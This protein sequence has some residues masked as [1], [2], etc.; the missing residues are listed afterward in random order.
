MSHRIAL[1]GALAADL[2]FPSYPFSACG[3]DREKEN[4]QRRGLAT[5]IELNSSVHV[6][7]QMVKENVTTH[8]TP[9][10]QPLQPH[11]NHAQKM[12]D[13]DE[14]SELHYEWS[15]SVQ[16]LNPMSNF[17]TLMRTQNRKQGPQ[18]NKKL[19]AM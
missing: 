10:W 19:R 2:L 5:I 17:G 14:C 9:K 7:N 1:E 3:I 12:R 18:E 15:V 6:C 4:R 16:I 11:E 13:F 8:S